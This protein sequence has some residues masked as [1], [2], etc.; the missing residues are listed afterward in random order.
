MAKAERLITLNNQ[1][2]HEQ[3]LPPLDGFGADFQP[4]AQKITKTPGLVM[5][6]NSVFEVVNPFTSSN[7]FP[8]MSENLPM[9][10]YDD[11]FGA[12]VISFEERSGVITN[13]TTKKERVLEGKGKVISFFKEAADYK[14]KNLNDFRNLAEQAAVMARLN[15]A[16][17]APGDGHGG[18]QNNSSG[19]SSKGELSLGSNVT[20]IFSKGGHKEGQHDHCK[21]CGGDLNDGKCSKCAA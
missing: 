8:A 3:K 12:E 7:N 20:S 16:A 5:P 1:F 9:A 6:N 19:L 14:L 15:A 21:S 4:Q 17:C 2:T 11:G 10:D 13:L 18:M